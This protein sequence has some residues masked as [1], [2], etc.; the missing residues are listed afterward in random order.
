MNTA[1]ALTSSSVSR[2]AIECMMALSLVRS[3]LNDHRAGSRDILRPGRPGRGSGQ[4]DPS[5]RGKVAQ[6]ATPSIVSRKKTNHGGQIGVADGRGDRG[7]HLRRTRQARASRLDSFAAML[8]MVSLWRRPALKSA[9]CFATY[10]SL[11]W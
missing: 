9:S 11:A 2:D 1:T 8:T 6:A 3:R 4:I 7:L 5:G 10:R